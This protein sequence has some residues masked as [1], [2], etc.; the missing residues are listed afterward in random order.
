MRERER[1]KN[2]FFPV[3]RCSFVKKTNEERTGRRPLLCVSLSHV[4]ENHSQL[5]NSVHAQLVRELLRGS[6][7]GCNGELAALKGSMEI[8]GVSGD[9]LNVPCF[10]SLSLPLSASHSLCRCVR[11]LHECARESRGREREEQ[12]EFSRERERACLL[13]SSPVLPLAR[14]I[15]VKKRRVRK[16]RRPSFS[17]YFFSCES[18]VVLLRTTPHSLD[19]ESLLLYLRNRFVFFDSE[20]SERARADGEPAGLEI[21]VVAAKPF[22]APIAHHSQKKLSNHAQLPDTKMRATALLAVLAAVALSRG[23]KAQLNVSDKKEPKRKTKTNCGEK[24]RRRRIRVRREPSL[25]KRDLNLFFETSPSALRFAPLLL[26]PNEQKNKKTGHP[27]R[28]GD[29]PQRV[30]C[31]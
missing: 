9:D 28:R 6:R 3:N 30:L 23:A 11:A 24:H 17:F 26:K 2:S 12:R 10:S 22:F 7:H 21:I 27:I 29:R 8:V 4:N 25:Q 14:S 5:V 13:P 31:L 20:E 15:R 16:R 1:K 18:K 19:L